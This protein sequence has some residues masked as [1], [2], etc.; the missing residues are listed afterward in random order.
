MQCEYSN[1]LVIQSTPYISPYILFNQ[2][3]EF[4]I[5]EE[6]VFG[7][8]IGYAK[9]SSDSWGYNDNTSTTSGCGLYNNVNFK[10]DPNIA[11][12]GGVSNK[13]MMKRQT[14]FNKSDTNFGKNFVLGTGADLQSITGQNIVV[15]NATYGKIYYINAIVRLKDLLFFW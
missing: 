5:Q 6:E 7:S 9:D 1:G 8:E 15:N 13:G 14:Y 3:T 4:S 2:H 12:C 10:G 11:R